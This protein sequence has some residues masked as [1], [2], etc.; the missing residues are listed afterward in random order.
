MVCLYLRLFVL[1]I[2]CSLK[3]ETY[4]PINSVSERRKIERENDV[5]ET[6]QIL[7]RLN[8]TNLRIQKKRKQSIYCDIQ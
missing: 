2:M 4:E 6:I 7:Q 8:L 3:S 5:L 1:Y